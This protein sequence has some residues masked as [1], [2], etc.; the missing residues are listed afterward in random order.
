MK[1]SEI[2][3]AFD[4]LNAK[5]QYALE[6]LEEA[7]ERLGEK[8]EVVESPASGDLREAARLMS[9]SELN[10]EDLSEEEI[11]NLL[12]KS[13]QEETVNKV[14]FWAM[15]LPTDTEANSSVNT[16]YLGKRR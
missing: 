1:V 12:V 16:R 2:Q 13:S 3:K 9:K 4:R 11:L 6:R 10:K 14:G 8:P 15:P 7:Y 5:Y